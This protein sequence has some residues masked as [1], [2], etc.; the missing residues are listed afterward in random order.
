VSDD[1]NQQA[2]APAGAAGGGTTDAEEL[3]EIAT[4]GTV[5]PILRP[6]TIPERREFSG[7]ILAIVLVVVFGIEVVGALAALVF[8]GAKVPDLKEIMPLILGPTVALVGSVTG[9]YFGTQEASQ[10]QQQ[11]NTPP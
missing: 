11:S 8:F 9:F 10:T 6:T 1:Q 5:E 7:Q 2:G 4:P 3:P